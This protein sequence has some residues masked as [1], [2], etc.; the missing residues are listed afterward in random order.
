MEQAPVSRVEWDPREKYTIG[1]F[2]MVNR[3][4]TLNKLIHVRWPAEGAERSRYAIAEGR[5]AVE[6][7]AAAAAATVPPSQ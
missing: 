4:L 6:S 3:S 2:R 7:G 1:Q 5:T